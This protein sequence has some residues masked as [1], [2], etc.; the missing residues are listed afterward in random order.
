PLY[1]RPPAEGPELRELREQESRRI[2][3]RYEPGPA[4]QVQCVGAMNCATGLMGKSTM[5]WVRRRPGATRLAV[6]LHRLEQTPSLYPLPVEISIPSPSGGTRKSVIVPAAGPETHRFL[7]DL[8]AD[9]PPGAVLDVTL[10]P[11]RAVSAP[12]LLAPRSLFVAGLE[13][14]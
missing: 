13:Q 8:P 11:E 2:P 9:L 3:E 7:L 12:R 5:I 1:R 6:T 10:R 14:E 4:A